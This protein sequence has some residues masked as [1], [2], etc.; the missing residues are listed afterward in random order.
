MAT[1]KDTA[2]WYVTATD[3]FL[4]GWGGATGKTQKI[5]V[6][7]ND[8]EQARRVERN[9]KKDRTLGNVIRKD[10]KPSYSSTKYSVSWKKASECPLWNQ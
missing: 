6:L 5:V 2:K 3:R 8:I 4:S 10:K 7:C 9:M 1:K